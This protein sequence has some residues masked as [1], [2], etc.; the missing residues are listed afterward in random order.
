MEKKKIKE[1]ELHQFAF[2]LVKEPQYKVISDGNEETQQIR[3][4]KKLDFGDKHASD[5]DEIKP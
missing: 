4:K 1:D 5:E 2:N 3:K